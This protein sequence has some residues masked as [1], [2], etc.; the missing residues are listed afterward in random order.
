MEV[1]NSF[2]RAFNTPQSQPD[3]VSSKTKDLLA[4]RTI[5]TMLHSLQ[6]PKTIAHSSDTRTGIIRI[7]DDE[8]KTLKVLDAMAAVLV[9]EHEITAVMAG[10]YDGSTLQVIASVVH[11]TDS[12]LVSDIHSY[13]QDFWSRMCN[14][15]VS[16]NPRT[17]K[18]NGN[19]SDS[20]MNKSSLPILRDYEDRVPTNLVAA[21]LKGSE[22]LLDVYLT[23]HW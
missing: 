18:T 17:S 1:I 4:F 5:I 19:H 21:S 14:F 12:L 7:T 6:S 9:R 13:F 16:I 22:Y 2:L 11:P 20:L 8:R 10:P 15:L 23:H 3:S